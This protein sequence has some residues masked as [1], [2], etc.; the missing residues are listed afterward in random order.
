VPHRLV[1]AARRHG[2]RDE[3][4][5]DAIRAVPRAG[6]V[7]A[8]LVA[9]AD[10]DAPLPIPHDQVTTQP[11]LSAQMIEALQLTGTE[12]VLEIG[13][14]YGYQ[15][16]LLATL[17]RA[18]YSVD[19]WADLAEAARGHLRAHGFDNVEV[20]VGDGTLG[21]ADA[22]PFDAVLVSAA[23]PDV[24]R[25]LAE[26]LREGGRLVQPIGPGGAEQVWLFGKDGGVLTP[27]RTITG[28]R[29]V[30][31]VSGPPSGD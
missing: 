3:R 4:L 23:F 14:G 7:P 6:F 25:P 22:A 13:T 11:S 8:H 31:L 19:R 21:A 5:L 24:P 12:T 18:V 30:P 27:R 20:V 26:Q 10:V 16:A 2:V 28:A 29:F 1:D 17:A 9:E 15:T